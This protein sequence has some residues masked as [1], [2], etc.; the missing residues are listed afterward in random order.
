MRPFFDV[1]GLVPH[2]PT[3]GIDRRMVAF[4]MANGDF[5][6]LALAANGAGRTET[7]DIF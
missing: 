2:V 7:L 6:M 1:G 5:Q 3:D 4:G